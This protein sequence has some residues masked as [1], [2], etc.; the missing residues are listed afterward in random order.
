L[1][2]TKRGS[3]GAI[4]VNY[5]GFVGTQAPWRKLDLLN[6]TEYATLLNEAY[7]AAGQPIRFPNPSSYGEGTDWQEAVFNDNALIQNHE[8]SISGGSERST[9]Y[10]S[11]GY[12]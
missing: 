1:I 10:G 2:T 6:A 11:F 9:Y 5:N 8:L 12:L 4:K 7:M 3:S